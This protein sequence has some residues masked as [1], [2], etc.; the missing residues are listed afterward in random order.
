MNKNRIHE[1]SVI[2]SVKTF[3]MKSWSIYKC[4]RWANKRRWR[5]GWP[6]KISWSN[7]CLHVNIFSHIKS[8]VRIPPMIKP[9][10]LLSHIATSITKIVRKCICIISLKGSIESLLREISSMVH[11]S[12]TWHKSFQS[13][14]QASRTLESEFRMNFLIGDHLI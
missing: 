11:T 7:S 6:H 9:S 12:R 1:E 3:T 8:S 2:A 10:S 13:S 4:W 14:F 5:W